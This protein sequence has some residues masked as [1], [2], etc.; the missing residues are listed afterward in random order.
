MKIKFRGLSSTTGSSHVTNPEG[1]PS[2]LDSKDNGFDRSSN[3]SFSS[4][5][6]ESSAVDNRKCV[7]LSINGGGVDVIAVADDKIIHSHES[8]PLNSITNSSTHSSST[9]ATSTKTNSTDDNPDVDDWNNST[10]AKIAASFAAALTELQ[11]ELRDKVTECEALYETASAL[12]QALQE[13]DRLLQFERNKNEKL[14]L[15]LSMICTFEE[16]DDDDDNNNDSEESYDDNSNSRRLDSDLRRHNKNRP[17]N[18]ASESKPDPI[19][20]ED[21]I[22]T[23]LRMR[24]RKLSNAVMKSP[25]TKHQDRLAALNLHRQL[26]SNARSNGMAG[27]FS[28][29]AS[30]TKGT[31]GTALGIMQDSRSSVKPI[32]LTS[33]HDRIRI[34]SSKSTPVDVDD[35][36]SSSDPTSDEDSTIQVELTKSISV[37]AEPSSTSSTIDSQLDLVTDKQCDPISDTMLVPF[38]EEHKQDDVRDY[39]RSTSTHSTELTNN[40]FVNEEID[41]ISSSPRMLRTVSAE[42]TIL[43]QTKVS[44]TLP[45]QANFYQIILERD[46]AQANV[47]RLTRE[48][49]NAK[50]EMRSMKSRLDVSTALVEIS[51][52]EPSSDA[53]EDYSNAATPMCHNSN[54]STNC[55]VDNSSHH[56]SKRSDLALS[57]SRRRGGWIRGSSGRQMLRKQQQI[58]QNVQDRI[59]ECFEED[60][61]D[62]SVVGGDLISK[63][64]QRLEDGHGQSNSTAT[65]LSLQDTTRG[66]GD[67]SENYRYEDKNSSEKRDKRNTFVPRV[68]HGTA[69][70]INCDDDDDESVRDYINAI[71]SS[72]S[73]PGTCDADKAGGDDTVNT[74]VLM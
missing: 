40:I 9:G 47:R 62:L 26:S 20:E 41:S 74:Y 63:K 46:I 57:V 54:S 32:D 68:I 38:I 16:A 2:R 34:R 44:A 25:Q 3:H 21:T 70:D 4:C 23:E 33:Q 69:Y 53:K 45:C 31:C 49:K 22:T 14:S 27:A 72:T 5:G 30:G 56:N 15:K 12:S 64:I 61:F 67:C 13:S 51:Y 29:T 11:H 66:S 19:E 39:H 50:S 42:S 73:T 55:D 37:K 52:S 8:A 48:L 7:P 6:N 36:Y 58:H 35:L 18:E 65:A 71:A 60:N 59:D 43:E 24:A 17:Q 28:A 10:S 1:S